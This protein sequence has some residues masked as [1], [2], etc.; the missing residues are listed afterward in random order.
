MLL[1]LKEDKTNILPRISFII[2]CMGRLHHL[3][4]TLPKNINWNVDYPNLEFILLD[5]NSS[6]GLAEWI[7]KYMIKLLKSGI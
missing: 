3:A 4:Q 5:Y 6:D 7:N 1:K 2:A